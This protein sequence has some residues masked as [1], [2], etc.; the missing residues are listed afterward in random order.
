MNNDSYQFIKDFAK[1]FRPE[2][3]KVVN[4]LIEDPKFQVCSG[5]SMPNQHHYGD[6]GLIKHT[7]EV[8]N[9]TSLVCDQYPCYDID[10]LELFFAALFHDS[11]KMFDYRYDYPEGWHSADH[12]RMIH[13]I[14]RSGIIWNDAIKTNQELYDKYFEKVLHAILSHHMAREAGSPVA[15]K[16]R[17][18]WIVT[19]CDNMSARMYDADTLD[20]INHNKG[21]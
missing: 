2:V 19:L 18:A 21:K 10:R 11:G 6:R 5:S 12:K 4:I 1:S 8:I 16:S 15:P 13:H 20:I 9:L 3:R 17:V 14:S 7:A